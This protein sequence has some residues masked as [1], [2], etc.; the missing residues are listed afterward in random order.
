MIAVSLNNTVEEMSGV[1]TLKV[2]SI[3]QQQDILA[4]AEA[5]NYQLQ[6][7]HNIAP[8]MEIVEETRE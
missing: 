5:D 8:N 7:F 3:Q 6:S 2:L 4:L 1:S